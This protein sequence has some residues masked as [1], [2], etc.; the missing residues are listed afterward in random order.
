MVRWVAGWLAGWM[1]GQ[2][3]KLTT[4]FQ[5]QVY[6][7]MEGAHQT[8]KVALWKREQLGSI[9]TSTLS[10]LSDFLIT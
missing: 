4:C 2:M 9:G 8:G 5:R 6:K 1:E 7:G 10:V 3:G